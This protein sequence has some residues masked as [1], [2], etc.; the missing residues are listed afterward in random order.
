MATSLMTFP[1][2]IFNFQ[3]FFVHFNAWRQITKKKWEKMVH[4]L[5]NWNIYEIK[6]KYTKIMKCNERYSFF[7]LALF[8][9]KTKFP[10]WIFFFLN[11]FIDNDYIFLNN[12]YQFV[13]FKTDIY[14]F[15]SL[16]S[17]LSVKPYCLLFH[18]L[19]YL[20]TIAFANAS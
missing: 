17:S 4:A 6:W 12:S 9:G 2:I 1:K 16:L 11:K 7:E 19:W 20:S 8:W 15:R 5:K 14:F 18:K 3:I 13:K 10:I